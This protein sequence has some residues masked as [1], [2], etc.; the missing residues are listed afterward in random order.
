MANAHFLNDPVL[1]HSDDPH[2]VSLQELHARLVALEYQAKKALEM[3]AEAL[4]P[5]PVAPA[6]P[7]APIAEEPVVHEG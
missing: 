5:Q 4:E 3:P 6:A 1:R 7:E 2:A